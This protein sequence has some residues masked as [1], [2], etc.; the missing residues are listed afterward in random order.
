VAEDGTANTTSSDAHTGVAAQLSGNTTSTGTKEGRTEAALVLASGDLGAVAVN[1]GVAVLLLLMLL[2]VLLVVRL[3]VLL[4][5]LLRDVDSLDLLG[6]GLAG[7]SVWVRPGSG[8][9][10]GAGVDLRVSGVLGLPVTSPSPASLALAAPRTCPETHVEP[11]LVALV[12]LA[13]PVN[14]S[15][16]S[17]E[18]RRSSENGPARG[19]TNVQNAKMAGELALALALG[20]DLPGGWEVV[21]LVA[22]CDG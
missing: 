7:S 10:V 14:V 18:S 16:M 8:R 5:V 2:V 9:G 3:V 6:V 17:S 21:D 22:H 11:L 20:I 4:V 19:A 12:E 13:E 1:V 15:Y